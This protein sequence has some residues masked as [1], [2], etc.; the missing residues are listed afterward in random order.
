MY[1]YYLITVI[2][3]K[4]N[5]V[6]FQ[7]SKKGKVIGPICNVVP[8]AEQCTQVRGSS[9][10]QRHAHILEVQVGM[11][12]HKAG[13]CPRCPLQHPQPSAEHQCCAQRHR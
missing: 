3:L 8:R 2:L 1:T 5:K 10:P 4:N 6:T 11:M 9:E 7:G 13:L 12:L